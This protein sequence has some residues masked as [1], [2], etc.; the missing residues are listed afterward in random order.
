MAL[1]Y[2]VVDRNRDIDESYKIIDLE[3]GKEFSLWVTHDRR[4]H[5]K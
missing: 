3:Y 5:G 1:Y 2:E 4:L